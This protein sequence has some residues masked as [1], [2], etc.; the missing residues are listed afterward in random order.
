MNK[1][2]I[3]DTHFGH[4]QIIRY[5]IR[6]FSSIEEMDACLIQNWNDTVSNDDIVYHLGDVSAYDTIKTA[7]IIRQLN[8]YKVLVMGNHDEHLTPKEWLEIGFDEVSAYP[9]L[10]DCWYLLSHKP[11][12]IN[13]NMPYANIFGHVHNNPAY[14]TESK[15]TRCVCVE[16]TEYRPVIMCMNE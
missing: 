6:P 11:L 8:G 12:Y 15:Q 4:E 5:E 13:S 2:V 7:E 16:R 10:V 9:I 3:S 14:L 1:Y